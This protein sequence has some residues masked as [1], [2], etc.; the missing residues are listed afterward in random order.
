MPC[1]AFDGSATPAALPARRE[2]ARPLRLTWAAWQL[3][4][5]DVDTRRARPGGRVAVTLYWQAQAPI[6]QD[7]HVFVHLEGDTATG[8]TPGILGPGRR[9]SRLLDLP[10]L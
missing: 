10:H 3:I 7:Y 6:P 9:A 2:A 5:Y 4:G 1:Y 8:S